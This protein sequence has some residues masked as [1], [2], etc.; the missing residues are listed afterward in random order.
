MNRQSKTGRQRDPLDL[1]LRVLRQDTLPALSDR[2]VDSLALAATDQGVLSLVYRRLSERPEELSGNMLARLEARTRLGM[3][4]QLSHSEQ[5]LHLLDLLH[6][7]DI[8]A[9][10]LKGPVLSEHVY[11]EV[12][13]RQSADLD[14]LVRGNDVDRAVEVVTAAGYIADLQ[15]A[16]APGWTLNEV[17][18]RAADSA[19]APVELHWRLAPAYA[20]QDLD[21]DGMWQRTDC[22]RFSG[23]DVSVLAPED[24][25]LYLCVHGAKHGWS[26]LKWICDL[27]AAVRADRDLDWGTV[28]A[29]ASAAGCRRRVLLGLAVARGVLGT[30][31]PETLTRAGRG[32]PVLLALRWYCL[33]LLRD[34]RTF[35]LGP[36]LVRYVVFSLASLERRRDVRLALQALWQYLHA[37][38]ALAAAAWRRQ[39]LS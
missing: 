29:R 17:T 15:S 11:G 30:P 23:R 24:L 1:V 12:G 32:D 2:D 6:E 5:L 36:F 10:P 39:M 20:G 18:L 16:G 38:L 21:L 26:R 25:I 28:L 35:D 34:P 37:S 19:L 27:D 7:H 3:I 9:I 8:P 22:I 4:N 14:L 33:R 13:L 31:V